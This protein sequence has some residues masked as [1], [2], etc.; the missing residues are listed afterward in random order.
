MDEWISD[1]MFKHVVFSLTFFH[2]R[3]P[4][5]ESSKEMNEEFFLY[6][7]KYFSSVKYQV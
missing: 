4:K 5:R 6:K 2:I 7:C 3:H 1:S